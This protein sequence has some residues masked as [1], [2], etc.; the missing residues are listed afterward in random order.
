M[1]KVSYVS[2]NDL[3]SHISLI[4]IIS[5]PVTLSVHHVG[6][7]IGFTSVP[8]KARSKTPYSLLAVNVARSSFPPFLMPQ[9][10]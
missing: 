5:G 10:H 1:S 7:F 8:I 6:R 4:D 2:R 9:S 3:L